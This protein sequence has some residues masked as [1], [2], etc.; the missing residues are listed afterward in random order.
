MKRSKFVKIL[1]HSDFDPIKTHILK[2]K[3]NCLV[4]FYANWC[5]HCHTLIHPDKS[6][7]LSLIERV[8]EML[9]DVDVC[10]FDCAVYGEHC[11]K[12]SEDAPELIKGYPTLV[13]YRHGKPTKH[14]D[15]ERTFDNIVKFALKNYK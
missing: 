11:M 10:V 3:S 1:K 4:L 2:D 12:I 6:N 5:P 13:Y 14:F 15:G 9:P 7:K 8:A